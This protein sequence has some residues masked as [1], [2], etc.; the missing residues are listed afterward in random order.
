M[1]ESEMRNRVVLS[2]TLL[3]LTAAASG[4]CTRV[5][6]PT[7]AQ[8]APRVERL[9]GNPIVIPAMLGGHDGENI[10]GP[11][12][13]RVPPW[14]EGRLGEYY[15]YFA[16]HAGTYIRM[17]Y[18]DDVTGPWKVYD[19]GT[20]HIEDTACNDITESSYAAYRHV[21]SPDVHVDPESRQIRM[22]FHCPVYISGPKDS[23]DS[24]RQVTLVATSED[25]LRF[26]ATSEPLGNSYFRVF[27][28]AGQRYALGMPG[29]FYR[30]ADGLGG[31][32]KGP[33]L[34]SS[35]MRHSAVTVRDGKLMVLYT[36]VGDNPERILFSEI[37]LAPDWMK[38]QATDPVTTLEPELD[39]EGANLP[40]EPSVRGYAMEGV[41]Q[42]RDPALFE[43]DGRTY[44]L[45]S[46]AG[47]SGIAIAELFWH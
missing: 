44:L 9:P 24:Y 47:E 8:S 32:E 7:P 35:D 45:Y 26:K 40:H 38:W 23:D 18:A 13:I 27:P 21:A 22:Y 3:L 30:S 6:A 2:L 31:F 16:H 25:G 4:G 33:T 37:D 14:V 20:L 43:T 28:W 17:A 10:N 42:L 34:F 12:L 1:E 39:W 5:A 11:S 36:V 46:V 29:I 41:R 19:P 15:L